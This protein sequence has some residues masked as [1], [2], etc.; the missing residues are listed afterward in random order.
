MAAVIPLSRRLRGTNN[1]NNLTG[2]P[3]VGES[4]S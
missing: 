2:L 4:G 3:P 1:D